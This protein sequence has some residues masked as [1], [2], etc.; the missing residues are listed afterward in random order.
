LLAVLLVKAIIYIFL[1]YH[2]AWI[3]AELNRQIHQ[4][5]SPDLHVEQVSVPIWG[6]LTGTEF[7][8][9]KITWRDSLYHK[10]KQSLLEIPKTALGIRLIPLL[11][12]KIILTK[13]HLEQAH[14]QLFTDEKGYSNGYLLEFSKKNQTNSNKNT[15]EKNFELSIR[16][17]NI[18][19]TSIQIK[20]KKNA[21]DF[22]FLIQEM[23]FYPNFQNGA[24]NGNLALDLY[25]KSLGFN[26]SQGRFLQNAQIHF[27]EKI[28]FDT[29]HMLHM[30]STAIRINDEIFRT[31]LMIGLGALDTL[32]IQIQKPDA[33]YA[34]VIPLLTDTIQK[35]M[36][37][38]E[39]KGEIKAQASITG[40]LSHKNPRIL[41]NFDLK[42]NKAITPYVDLDKLSTQGYFLNQI[43]IYQPPEDKNSALVLDSVR[44]LSHEVNFK[45]NRLTVENLEK[46]IIRSNLEFYGKVTALKKLVKDYPI[47][48][49]SGD[50]K[51]FGLL[52]SAPNL[53]IKDL[54]NIRG[55]F[56]FSNVQLALPKYGYLI[57]HL[58]CRALYFD[59]KFN[60][61]K[62]S[63]DLTPIKSPKDVLTLISKKTDLTIGDKLKVLSDMALQADAGILNAFLA[64]KGVSANSG[65]ISF[66]GVFDDYIDFDWRNPPKVKG[67]LKLNHIDLTVLD[68]PMRFA[69]ITGD[70]DLHRN[71]AYTDLLEAK[72]TDSDPSSPHTPFDL[73]FRRATFTLSEA[74]SIDG[75]F[76]ISGQ[77]VSLSR[78]L[79]K[80]KIK[81]HRGNL[82]IQGNYHGKVGDLMQ[83]IQ[84]TRAD[85]HFHQIDLILPDLDFHIIN[86]SG[87]INLD[88]GK[89]NLENF[90]TYFGPNVFQVDIN[91]PNMLSYLLEDKPELD[92][93]I[94]IQSAYLYLPTRAEKLNN[95]DFSTKDKSDKIRVKNKPSS[96]LKALRDYPKMNFNLKIDID[97][98]QT[99]VL[100]FRN[101]ELDATKQGKILNLNQAKM[102]IGQGKLHL[103]GNLKAENQGYPLSLHTHF[104]RAD[105]QKMQQFIQKYGA[106]NLPIS[107]FGEMNLTS[108]LSAILLEDYQPKKHSIQGA[109]QI[110]LTSLQVQHLDQVVNKKPKALFRSALGCICISPFSVKST[111]QNDTIYLPETFI[112]T[113][114]G[115]AF[116]SGKSTIDGFSEFDLSIPRYNLS[117][118][119][120]GTK[121]SKP[122]KIDAKKYF[123][124][125]IK[126]LKAQKSNPSSAQD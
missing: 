104:Q 54:L 119:I 49:I 11:Q 40:R 6:V 121:I 115:P 62:L 71:Q 24:I 103:F 58:N 41:V 109:Y 79:P 72:L 74:L 52:E 64:K 56:E 70:F 8:I 39:I 4:N 122:N 20:D 55:G 53:N 37:M 19:N 47:R 105:L 106:L 66:D 48:L 9:S 3:T 38:A 5:I 26:T 102:N 96:L 126:S 36:K 61:D 117:N 45:T 18:S 88:R 68:L 50:F 43:D 107:V 86:T 75:D 57:H 22:D 7:E 118:L 83:N 23:R 2:E 125:K 120:F 51:L 101:F 112:V 10:H 32:N 85:V 34:K 89:I 111:L 78:F 31:S 42:E 92:A 60:I 116:L 84:N 90:K 94:H 99:E 87:K 69:D 93:D 13:I 35:S 44:G 33:L 110:D 82:N 16:E 30:P 81:L 65:K 76:E 63:L 80:E 98:I 100:D 29:S 108:Q 124:V 97:R 114:H 15:E 67:K 21:Q 25:C 27:K 113:Q 59:K 77:A 73:A 46:P 14:F 17:I 123:E 95:F 1:R 91:S 12:K 28:E